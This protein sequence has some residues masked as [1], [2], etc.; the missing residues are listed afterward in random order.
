MPFCIL[1]FPCHPEV[2]SQSSQPK[3]A[4]VDSKY[5]HKLESGL[6]GLFSIFDPGTMILVS[7]YGGERCAKE[8]GARITGV[9]FSEAKMG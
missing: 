2:I 6:Q 3:A 9:F 7:E 5:C 8:L 4:R 1:S